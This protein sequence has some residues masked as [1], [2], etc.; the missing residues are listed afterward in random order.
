M[1]I[2]A[3]LGFLWLCLCLLFTIVLIFLSNRPQPLDPPMTFTITDPV[4]HHHVLHQS[5]FG[6]TVFRDQLFW[7]NIPESWLCRVMIKHCPANV[8]VGLQIEIVKINLWETSSDGCFFFIIRVKGWSK[9]ERSQEI[10]SRMT[11]IADST[12]GSGLH[13]LPLPPP[14]YF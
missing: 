1:W 11:S 13:S 10:S 5:P 6:W 12:W 9:A 7:H 14:L 3:Q 8:W 4:H 2:S